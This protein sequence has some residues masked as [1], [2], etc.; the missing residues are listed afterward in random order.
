MRVPKPAAGMIPQ[1]KLMRQPPANST[2]PD[3]DALTCV[4]PALVRGLLFQLVAIVP[5]HERAPEPHRWNISPR[6]TR[7]LARKIAPDLPTNRS[8]LGF[9]KPPLQTI[10][11]TDN[12]R[13][14]PW[15]HA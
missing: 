5:D 2:V 10:F 7:A 3:C 9:R 13:N 11:Q 8:R 4:R 1:R 12:I 15:Q 14:S 6:A